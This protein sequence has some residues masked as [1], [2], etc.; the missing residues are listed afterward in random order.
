MAVPQLPLRPW[1]G[2]RRADPTTLLFGRVLGVR[3][4]ALGLGALLAMRHD[5]PVRGW[6]EA[7]GLADTGDTLFTALSFRELPDPGRWLVLVA[8]GSGAALSRL[9]SVS[10]DAG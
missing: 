3:D 9:A 2:E 10:V 6:I 5:A 1:V 4:L 7:G 8:V